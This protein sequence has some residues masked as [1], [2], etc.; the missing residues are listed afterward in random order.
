MSDLVPFTA[1]PPEA[2]R[3][4]V[5]G[6]AGV[7]VHV[8]QLSRVVAGTEFVPKALRGSPAAVA[9][10]I[11]AGRE[12]GVGPMTAMQ[13]LHVIEGRPS[14]S[15]TLMRALT[16]SAGHR[17]V[18]AE[19]SNLRVTV[20]G[21]RAGEDE[22]SAVT[23]TMDDARQAGL[24]RRTPWRNYPRA[25]LLARATGELCRAVFADV[26]LGMPYTAEEMADLA[27]VLPPGMVESTE[28]DAPVRKPRVK[29]N[30]LAT[31]QEPPLDAP[32]PPPPTPTPSA[33]VEPAEAPHEP[34]PDEDEPPPPTPP[35]GSKE[36]TPPP[37]PSGA[38]TVTDEGEMTPDE[39]ASRGQQGMVHALLSEVAPGI[40]REERM[41]IAQAIIGARVRSFSQV[42]RAE[43]SRLIETLTRVKS[44]DDP[45]AYLSW[46]TDTGQEELAR[47][48]R[49]ERGE[50]EDAEPAV[51]IEFPHDDDAEPDLD[52]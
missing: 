1:P 16:L 39:P 45:S 44:S 6:W 27:N 24:D 5:D 8:E 42:T 47:R 20:R 9:A 36:S 34:P 51:V 13:H 41:R 29:R 12:I 43:C 28:G 30:T 26:V 52:S 2:R 22:W 23:W 14:M 4:V 18:I 33:P 40:E 38:V 37:R 48:E 21:Q 19:A 15:A 25:M 32:A 10:A 35:R 17:L 7:L 31:G 50:E 46:L 49:V 3:D 11:L